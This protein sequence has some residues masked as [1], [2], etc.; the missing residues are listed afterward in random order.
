M[1][2]TNVYVDAFNLYFACLKDGPYRWLNVAELARQS[3]PAHYLINRVRVFTALVHP[4]PHDPRQ[5]DRQRAYLRALETVPDLTVHLGQFLSSTVRMP[6]AHPPPGGPRTVEVL[7]SEEKGSD[8]NLATYLLV[9]AFDNDFEAAVVISDD[10]DLAEPIHV[11]RK[12][13]G[14]HVTVLSPRGRSRR[15]QQVATRFRQIRVDAIRN[16][17]FPPVLTD[18]HGTIHK[19]ASW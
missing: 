1:V 8:V 11:I 18:A 16:S 13:F 14:R 19:P 3:M 4:R 5:A 17:Q 9:D 2:R 7:K 10:S 15:L 12:K 6:L